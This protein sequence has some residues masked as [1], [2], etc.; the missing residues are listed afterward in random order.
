MHSDRSWAA[1][2]MAERAVREEMEPEAVAS[3]GGY[4]TMLEEV[5]QTRV[6]KESNLCLL[7]SSESSAKPERQQSRDGIR[8]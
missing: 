6:G 4:Y 2:A 3:W 1:L 5:N 8:Y 7:L